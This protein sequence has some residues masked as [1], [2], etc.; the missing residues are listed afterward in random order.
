[1]DVGGNLKLLINDIIFVCWDEING[2]LVNFL[3]LEE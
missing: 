2:M 3:N 1:M